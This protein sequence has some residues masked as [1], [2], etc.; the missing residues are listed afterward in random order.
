MNDGQVSVCRQRS[1]GAVRCGVTDARYDAEAPSAQAG[2]FAVLSFGVGAS[3][4]SLRL[5]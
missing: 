3:E 1:G 5:G 4:R 2:G